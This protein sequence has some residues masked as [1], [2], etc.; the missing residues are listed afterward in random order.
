MKKLSKKRIMETG[1]L[2][3]LLST[4]IAS[5]TFLLRIALDI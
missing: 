1:R 2:A 3:N 5:R 4:E